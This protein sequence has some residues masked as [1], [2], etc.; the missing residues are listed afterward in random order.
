MAA[1]HTDSIYENELARL[2][3]SLLVMGAKAEEI[4]GRAM[5]ALTARDPALARAAMA[6][7]EQIDQLEVRIDESALMILARRQPVASDLR[8]IATVLKMVT[9]LERVGDLGVNIC[10]RA[11]ELLA[12][13]TLPEQSE[14]VSLSADVSRMLHD[15][16]DAFA[17]ADAELAR[18]VLGRDHLVDASFAR[19]FEVLVQRM[20]R[21]SENIARATRLQS[22]ARYLERIADHATNVAEMVVFMVKGKD[23]RHTALAKPTK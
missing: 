19:I 9:D 5:Q 8:L 23:V 3:E 10:E 21:G 2:R 1:T 12:E 20:M 16:L 11:V 14:I 13:P 18:D 6:L 15:A 22:L 17:R 7:D 4:L